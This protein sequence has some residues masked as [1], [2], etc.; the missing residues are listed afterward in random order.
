MQFTSAFEALIAASFDLSLDLV[1]FG[2]NKESPIHTLPR[3]PSPAGPKRAT[4]DLEVGSGMD[5][6][7][8]TFPGLTILRP[9]KTKIPERKE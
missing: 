8:K 7:L 4:L 3:V 6:N 2:V 5:R 9:Y 1:Q